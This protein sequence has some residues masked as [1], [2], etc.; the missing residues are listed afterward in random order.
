VPRI[1]AVALGALLR[2]AAR[3][4]L[5]R[6]GQVDVRADRLELLDDESPAGRCLQRNLEL[7]APEEG[8][9]ATD[10]RAVGRRDAACA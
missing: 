9:E 1:S 10:S 6:L 2:P 3:R 8:S 7:P 4:G 5:G